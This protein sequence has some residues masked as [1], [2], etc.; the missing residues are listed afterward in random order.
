M[1]LV[2]LSLSRFG[3]FKSVAKV[4][5][6]GVKHVSYTP[7]HSTRNKHATNVV[8]PYQHQHCI[9]SRRQRQPDILFDPSIWSTN[10][11]WHH[12]QPNIQ[13]NPHITLILY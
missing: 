13:R 6:T 1:N 10:P 2:L 5:R 9:L 8:M 4:I 3:K 7:A 12:L 11:P